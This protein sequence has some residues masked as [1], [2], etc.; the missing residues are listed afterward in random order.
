MLG[1]QVLFPAKQ[2]LARRRVL[3][4]QRQSGRR[5]Q[6]FCLAFDR[7]ERA[8]VLDRGSGDLGSGLFGFDESSFQMR[9]AAGVRDAVAGDNSVVAVVTIGE[10][11]LGSPIIPTLALPRRPA[12]L[13]APE[14]PRKVDRRQIQAPPEGC[15]HR[16]G[17]LRW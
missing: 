8:H 2:L 6:I 14:S 9:P 13:P 10:R 4:A 3:P 12:S 1:Q 16:K 11:Q 17:E 5:L 15:A 7:V